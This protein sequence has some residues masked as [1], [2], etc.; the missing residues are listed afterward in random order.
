[1]REEREKVAAAGKRSLRDR[2][3][4]G[5]SFFVWIAS[6]IR[7]TPIAQPTAGHITTG[8]TQGTG[9][10][11]L[12]DGKFTGATGSTSYTI[13]DIVS[14]LKKLGLINS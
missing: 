11:V 7:S 4:A 8:Y 2:Q 5:G 1:M 6:I 12:I 3:G 10:S 14:A 9:E 13:G